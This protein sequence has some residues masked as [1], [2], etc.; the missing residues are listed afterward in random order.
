MGKSGKGHFWTIDPKSNHE[1]QEEGSLRRRTRGFRRRQQPKPYSQPYTH[2]VPYCSE[3]STNR[4]DER[5]EFT[6]SSTQ[7]THKILEFSCAPLFFNSYG[8]LFNCSFITIKFNQES[9]DLF[10]NTNYYQDYNPYPPQGYLPM[11]SAD[12]YSYHTT[13]T[14][15]TAIHSLPPSRYNLE[16]G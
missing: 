11:H 9:D 16:T 2:Y 5:S 8:F 4:P 3:F 10:Q 12:T 7:F 13:D 14:T 15:G 1:F 6:V